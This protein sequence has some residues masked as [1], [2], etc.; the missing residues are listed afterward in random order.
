MLA[1]RQRQV[2]RLVRHLSGREPAVPRRQRE[3]GENPVHYAMIIAGV[4]LMAFGIL[5]ATFTVSYELLT[6]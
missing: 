4:M 1:F 2:R 5:I 3:P 6:R